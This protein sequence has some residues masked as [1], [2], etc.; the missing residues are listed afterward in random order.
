MKTTLTIA[1]QLLKKPIKETKEETPHI[2]VQGANIVHQADILYLPSDRGFKYAL[3]VVDLGSR[4][5]DAIPLRNHSAVAVRNAF[6]KVYEEH[7][8]LK[9]PKRM[10]VDPGAEFKGVTKTYLTDN[11]VVIRYGKAGRSRQQA[12]AER[13]NQTIGDEIFKRQIE[14]EI[15]TD[16]VN[17]QWI[18]D[19]PEIIEDLNERYEVTKFKPLSNEPIITK[20]T[21]QLLMRGDRVRVLLDEPHDYFGKK[22][23]GRFRSADIRWSPMIYEIERVLLRPS[24]PPMYLVKGLPH[25]PYTRGQLQV[26][27]AF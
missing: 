21:K 11:G 10:E 13:R 26:V 1:E 6:K 19:L 12:L 24:Y 27:E 9:M 7:N 3:V 8:I 15:K 14:R 4:L 17:K 2:Q 20:R 18:K 5:T 23:H 16:K 22:L 25:T